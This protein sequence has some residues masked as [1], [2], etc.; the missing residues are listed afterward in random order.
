MRHRGV[1]VSPFTKDNRK[2]FIFDESKSGE[3]SA[4]ILPEYELI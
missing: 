3:F 4:D 2:G 1:D